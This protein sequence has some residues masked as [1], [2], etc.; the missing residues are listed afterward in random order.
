MREF[1]F[2]EYLKKLSPAL[3]QGI[4][5]D[6]ALLGNLLI[7]K[8]LMTEGIH[9]LETEPIDYIMDR[10]FTANLSDLAA[11]GAK[12][13]GVCVLLGLVMPKEIKRKSL[14]AAI[15][16]TCEKY[17]ITLIGG[18][19]CHG[20]SLTLSLTAI[21]TKGKNVLTRAGASAG[22]L[23]FLSRTVGMSAL[24]LEKRLS[25]ASDYSYRP[26]AEVS[27]GA[28]LGETEAVTSCID[29]SDGLGRDLSHIAKSSAVRI[30]LHGKDLPL[31]KDIEADDALC[32]GEEYALAFTVKS[33]YAKELR[34]RVRQELGRDIF[35]IGEVIAGQGVYLT[36]EAG[37]MREISS[38]GYEH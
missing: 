14:L 19:T 29:I 35:L 37:M 16:N 33:E 20:D 21:G 6:A 10:L 25:G 22:D 4:G 13:E 32:S 7:A 5:D 8:D 24:D 34:E 23:L 18:D 36:E 12:Q 27:L 11:M 1:E 15:E 30:N 26:P 28:L 17:K 38:F 2:I 3:P 9:F 31:C